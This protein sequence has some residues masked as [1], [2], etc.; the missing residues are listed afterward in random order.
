MQHVVRILPCSEQ[1]GQLSCYESSLML[2]AVYE[3][4]RKALSRRVELMQVRGLII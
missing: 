2:Q 4:M 1:A 3:S